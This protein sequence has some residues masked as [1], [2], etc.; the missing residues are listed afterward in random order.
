MLFSHK[1]FRLPGPKELGWS[2]TD[3]LESREFS[4]DPKGKTWEDW[5]EYV[6]KHYPVRYFFAVTVRDF[7]KYKIW[8]KVARPFEKA[9]YWFV[10][11]FVPSRRYHMLDL[12]QKGG[13]QYGWQDVPEKMLYAIFN[14]L[15]EYLHEESPNDLTQWYTREQIAVDQ[16]LKEQQ[17]NIDEARVI[18]RWWIIGR[19]EEQEAIS[20]MMT[21]WYE[22]KKAKNPDAKAYWDTLQEM[23]DGLEQKTDLMITR[24]MKIRRTLWT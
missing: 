11:H 22:A 23:E 14:L 3:A 19:K 5:D 6:A 8:F 7:L 10:S 4:D 24:V 18:H 17:D 2:D 21:K 12:R 20:N 15:G 1:L 13:Y 16:G 9:W